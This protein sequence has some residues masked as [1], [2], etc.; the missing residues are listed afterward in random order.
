MLSNFSPFY[1]FFQEDTEESMDYIGKTMVSSQ[2]NRI[3]KGL[4]LFD[5]DKNEKEEEDRETSTRKVSTL[6]YMTF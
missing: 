6:F 2:V 5:N 4:G 3:T 1:E